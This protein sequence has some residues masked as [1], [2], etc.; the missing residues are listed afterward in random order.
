[1]FPT[2]IMR[3]QQKDD[4]NVFFD[5]G[6]NRWVDIQIIFQNHTDGTRA[7][8][9]LSFVNMNAP[10]PPP[11]RTPPSLSLECNVPTNA[12]ASPF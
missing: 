7:Q 1:M 4:T 11:A 2:T 8:T 12:Y 10:P 9:P 3:A 5:K 6:N